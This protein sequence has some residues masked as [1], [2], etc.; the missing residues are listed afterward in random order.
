V[1]ELRFPAVDLGDAVVRLRPWRET[2]VRWQL[3]AFSDPWFQRFSDWAPESESAAHRRRLR[4][5]RA[6]R[7]GEQLQFAL[8]EPSDDELLLGGV[9]LH[10][11]EMD[12]R[13]AAVGYW[14]APEARGRGVATHA[15][16]LLA[17]W[18][19]DELGLARLALTCG[20]DNHASQSVA[21]RCGFRHEGVLRSHMPFKG[22]RRDTVVFGVLPD[23]L[24]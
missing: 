20:P 2:D 14:L 11:V 3:E 15:V 7:R 10:E 1:T 23:E 4:D 18:A 22:G 24:R 21:E 19:F 17:R 16:R 12:Q 6:R 8:V 5:E 13:R 9:S